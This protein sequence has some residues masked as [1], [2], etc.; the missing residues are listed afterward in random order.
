M[1]NKKNNFAELVEEAIGSDGGSSMFGGAGGGG[2]G[3]FSANGQK[4]AKTWSHQSP[5]S[6][7]MTGIPN[8]DEM[9][10][11]IS[12]E[13]EEAHKAPKR[14]PFPLETID[15]SL[16]SAFIIL[17]NAEVQMKNCIRYNALING[18]K[19]KKKT[20]EFLK[21]KIKAIRQMLQ[22]ISEEL[23]RITLSN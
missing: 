19:D 10:G 9:M 13:E 1:K 17:G 18:K 4:G 12:S 22:G 2:G 16:V 11:I 20:L 23:D 14:K 21:D 3:T 8:A 6:R 5:P 7:G 15:D